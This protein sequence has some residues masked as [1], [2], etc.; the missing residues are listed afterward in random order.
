MD[1]DTLKKIF[2]QGVTYFPPIAWGYY[3]TKS[4]EPVAVIGFLISC[5]ISYLFRYQYVPKHTT[6]LEP[7]KNKEEQRALVK[8]SKQLI[9]EDGSLLYGGLLVLLRIMSYLI[10]YLPLIITHDLVSILLIVCGA[11]SGI[12]GFMTFLVL[13]IQDR[14]TPD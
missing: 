10:S 12:L 4:Q 3:L 1:F 2:D 13:L 5:L 8:E 9:R 7:S 6:N 11:I 14:I